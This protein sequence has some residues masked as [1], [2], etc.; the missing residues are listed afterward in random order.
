MSDAWDSGIRVK[1][2]NTIDLSKIRNLMT[3]AKVEISV[4][5]PSGM[6]HTNTLHKDDFDKPN[7]KRKGKYVGLYGED[8]LDQQPIETAELAKMLHYGTD[9]IPARPFLE[10]GIRQNLGKLKGA[11]KEEAQKLADGKKANW[12]KVGTMATGAISEF[13]RSD[14]FKQRVPNAASTIKWKGSDI[15]LIDGANMI[16]SL[17]YVINGEVHK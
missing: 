6:E 16:Q 10:E 14:Y 13:V 4:G 11:I 7:E 9:K 15:P 2:Q 8:P 1:I 17:H 3:E 5:F 12:N